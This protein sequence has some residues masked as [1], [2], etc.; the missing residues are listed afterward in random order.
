MELRVWLKEGLQKRADN[1]LIRLFCRGV[2][3][4]FPSRQ[5]AIVHIR[6][7]CG[8]SLSAL[9]H[10]VVEVELCIGEADGLGRLGAFL[11]RERKVGIRLWFHEI[12]VM[13]EL[14]WGRCQGLIRL[15]RWGY[16]P[17]DLIMHREL[18]LRLLSVL[19]GALRALLHLL[20]RY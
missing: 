20:E 4:Q 13:V 7:G 1:L 15:D 3:L 6:R 12:F 16:G 17:H 14:H 11:L 5:H 8:V 18:E 9:D 2:E 19:R 10:V